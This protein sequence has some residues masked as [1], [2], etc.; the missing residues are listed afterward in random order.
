M[1]G[2]GIFIR[3][4]ACRTEVVCRLRRRLMKWCTNGTTSDRWVRRPIVVS[5]V[6]AVVVC[7]CKNV[8]IDSVQAVYLF[9]GSEIIR[10]RKSH[11]HPNIILISERPASAISFVVA[12]IGCRGIGSDG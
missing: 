12:A 3:L 2:G 6:G 11:F 9:S 7:S 5:S 1:H 10:R 8:S 4:V